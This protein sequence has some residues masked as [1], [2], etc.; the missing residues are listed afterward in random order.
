MFTSP[1]SFRD[2]IWS[3]RTSFKYCMKLSIWPSNSDWALPLCTRRRFSES[4]LPKIIWKV[5]FSAG[6]VVSGSEAE[7][8]ASVFVI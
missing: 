8:A 6:D 3:R 7:E 2:I 4:V 5:L 1:D